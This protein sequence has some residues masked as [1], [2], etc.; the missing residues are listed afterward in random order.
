[1]T[2]P[3]LSIVLPHIPGWHPVD[4]HPASPPLQGVQLIGLPQLSMVSPHDWHP[5]ETHEPLSEP[6]DPP[7]SVGTPASAVNPPPQVS[8]HFPPLQD[9]PAPQAFPQAPQFPGSLCRSLQFEVEPASSGL[10]AL[11]PAGHEVAQTPLV[12]HTSV[13][14]QIET[15]APLVQVCP[16][17]HV[18]PQAPQ[19]RSLVW[20]SKQPSM[21]AVSQ[22]VV[23]GL[24]LHV[25][26]TLPPVPSSHEPPGEVDSPLQLAT[27]VPP[28]HCCV[29]P[30]VVPHPPQWEG[31]VWTSVQRPVPPE[32]GAVQTCVPV[33]HAETHA[34]PAQNPPPGQIGAQVPAEQISPFPQ[35]MPQVPQLLGSV[36]V[37]THWLP[38]CSKPVPHAAQLMPPSGCSGSPHAPPLLRP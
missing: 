36:V 34:P 12:V 11:W 24:C 2:F 30:H 5:S 14:G 37:C 26:G 18:L 1:M 28:T 31:S 17:V 16:A 29:S 25:H 19:F 21:P 9:C 33:G 27:H 3:Q 8:T 23:P 35:T 22:A 15:Q 7:A 32:A 10:H 38:H 4:T 13:P 20:R 6:P